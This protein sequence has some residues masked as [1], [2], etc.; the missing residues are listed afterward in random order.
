MNSLTL[1]SLI[2]QRYTTLTLTLSRQGQEREFCV[3]ALQEYYNY[4]YTSQYFTA[5]VT[6]I[7]QSNV[8]EYLGK[9]EEAE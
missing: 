8:E 5:D 9:Q 2:F 6:V 1:K 4:G 7:D 3:D